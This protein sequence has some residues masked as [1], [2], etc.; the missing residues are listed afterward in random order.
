MTFNYYSDVSL[1]FIK[2]EQIFARIKCNVRDIA[3]FHQK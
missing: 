1:F 2:L 3:N